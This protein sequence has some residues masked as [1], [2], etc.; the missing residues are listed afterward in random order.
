M[1][2]RLRRRFDSTKPT[3]LAF[4]A[5]LTSVPTPAWEKAQVLARRSNKA[6]RRRKEF[7]LSS[8]VPE[9]PVSV[10]WYSLITSWRDPEASFARSGGG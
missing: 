2:P 4:C 7:L 3:E 8:S 10:L 9:S 1:S 6:D 5:L